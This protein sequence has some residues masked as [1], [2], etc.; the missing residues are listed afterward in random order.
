VSHSFDQRLFWDGTGFVELHLGDAYPRSIALGR[1]NDGKDKSKVYDLFKPKGDLGSNDTFT[2]L[3]GIAPIATGDLGYVVVFTTDRSP[4]ETT[5]ILNGTRDVAF[6]RVSR[7]FT[8]M[9]EKGTSF[10][11]GASTQ[12]VMSAGAAATN[13][14]TWLTD[15]AADAAQADR[16]RLAAIAGDQFVVLWERWT[17]T[18]KQSTFAGTQALLLGA[19]GMVKALPKQLSTHHLSR[20]DDVVTLGAQALYVSGDGAAKKLTLNLITADLT[21]TSVDLP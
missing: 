13:K 1:F 12:E 19:D 16:P 17:G 14:L 8:T 3:G 4:S 9:D 5:A 2:R 6:L 18:D 20:A 15:Y 11:D 7:A 10:V 21:L